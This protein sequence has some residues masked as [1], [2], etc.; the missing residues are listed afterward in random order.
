MCNLSRFEARQPCVT[1]TFV[2]FSV[3]LLV[4]QDEGGE[5]EW[6]AGYFSALFPGISLEELQNDFSL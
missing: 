2:F 3:V 1:G 6:R 5:G 4:F